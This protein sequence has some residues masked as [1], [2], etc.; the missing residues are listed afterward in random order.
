MLSGPVKTYQNYIKI[1]EVI[2][3]PN[4]KM[5][6]RMKLMLMDAG[7]LEKCDDDVDVAAWR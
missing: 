1:N 6:V 5:K 3:G 2:L 4:A 7:T